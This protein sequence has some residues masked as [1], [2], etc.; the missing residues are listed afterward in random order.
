VARQAYVQDLR[1]SS[2]MTPQEKMR[3]QRRVEKMEYRMSRSLIERRDASQRPTFDPAA[4]AARNQDKAT[5]WVAAMDVR[6]ELPD[7]LEFLTMERANLQARTLMALEQYMTEQTGR[8]GTSGSSFWIFQETGTSDAEQ[9]LLTKGDLTGGLSIVPGEVVFFDTAAYQYMDPQKARDL[10]M[11]RIDYFV[12]RGAALMIGSSDGANPLI[13]E[14]QTLTRDEHGYQR[15]MNNNTVLVPDVFDQSSY[16][17]VAAAR[18]RLVNPSVVALARQRLTMLLLDRELE[19]NTMWVPI[20][21][22]GTRFDTIQAVFDLLPIDVNAKFASPNTIDEAQKVQGWIESLGVDGKAMLRE[23]AVRHLHDEKDPTKLKKG[24]T[25]AQVDEAITDFDKDWDRML[26]RLPDRALAGTTAPLVGED[27]FGTGDF[28]PLVNNDTG[29]LLLY[30]HGYKYPKDGDYR[31]Q[32]GNQL[33]GLSGARGIVMYSGARE[34]SATT[35]R[36]TVVA[37]NQSPGRGFRMELEIPVQQLGEKIVFEHNG[38]KYLLTDLPEATKVPALALFGDV[39]ID[40]YASLHDTISKEATD[41]L[42][43]SFQNAFTVFGIDFTEDVRKFFGTKNTADAIDLLKSVARFSDTLD[44]DEVYELQG[45]LAGQSAYMSAIEGMLPTLA[46]AGVAIDTWAGKIEDDTAEAAIARAMLLYAMSP[47]ADVE[48]ILSSSGFYVDNP[49]L[50]GAESQ[51]MPELF[52]R[53]FD[54]SKPDSAVRKELGKRINAKLSRGG[55]ESW[56]LDVNS[57]ELEGITAT[58]TPIRG[59]LQYG[60]AH[61]SEDSVV[62]NLMAQERKDSQS[63]TYHQGLMNI[64]GTGG[65]TRTKTKAFQRLTG[66]RNQDLEPIAQAPGSL[67]RDLTFIDTQTHGP[68]SRWQ[69]RTPAEHIVYNQSIMRMTQYRHAIDLTDSAFEKDRTKINEGID[70]IVNVLGLRPSQEELVHYWIRQVLYHPAEGSDQ[71]AFSGDLRPGDVLGATRTI[72]ENVRDGYFP[73]YDAAG[74]AFFSYDDLM[75]LFQAHQRGESTWAPFRKEGDPSSTAQKDNLGDWIAIAFGQAINEK[76][77]FDPIYRLDMAGFMNTY[78]A[79]LRD[80][81]HFMDITFDKHLQGRLLDPKT[82]ELL[83]VTLDPTQDGQITRSVLMATAGLEY[84]DLMRGAATSDDPNARAQAAAWRKRRLDSRAKWRARHKVRPVRVQSSRD[85][86]RNGIEVINKDADMHSLQRIIIALRHGTAMLNPGLYISMLPEQGWRMFLSEATNALSGESSLRSVSAVQRGVD[87]LASKASGGRINLQFAQYSADQLERFTR[88]I[89]E[90]GDDGAFTSLIISDM[91]WHKPGDSPGRVVRAFEKYASLGN[92]WQDPTWGTR[93]KDMARHYIEAIVREIESQPTRYAMS[94]DS[95]LD[96]LSTDPAYFARNHEELHQRA[97]NAVVDFRSLRN[98]PWSLALKRLYEPM[99]S[100]GNRLVR[101]GGTLLKLQAMYAT[102]NMNVLS[103]MTGMQ[104]LTAMTAIFFDAK[105]RPGSA[106]SLWWKARNDEEITDEDYKT[107]DMSSAIDSVNIA[108]AFIKGGVTQ[109]GLF[110]MGM[111]LG[112]VLSGEDDEAKR[113]RRLAQEQGAHLIMDPRRLETDFRN[114]DMI[115]LDWLPPQLG[116]AF[117]KMTPGENGEPGRQVAQMSWLIKPF[118]SPILGMEKFF[119]TGDF[120]YVTHGFMDAV[121]SLPL[122]NKGTWDDA[123]RTADE[124][125][126]L[127][128]EEQEVGTPTATKNTMWLLGSAVGVYENMLFENMFVNAIYAGLDT[129]DRDPSKMVLRDSDGVPQV[130]IEGNPRPNDVALQEFPDDNGT[131]DNKADDKI[132][133]GYMK[134]N[135][136]EAN[137]ASYTENHFTAAAVMSLFTGFD[138]DLMRTEMVVRQP[139]IDLPELDAKQARAAIILAT[140]NGQKKA[141]TLDRR[142]SLDEVTAALKAKY[143]AVKDWD[144]YNNLDANAKAFYL[145]SDNPVMD[146]LEE[147]GPDGREALNKSGQA[148]LFKGLMN[149]TITLEDE[150]MRGIAITPEVRKEIERDFYTDMRREGMDLGLTSDQAKDRAT[151]LMIGPIEDG[152]VM[153]FRDVLWSKEIPWTADLKYKQ[154]NTTYVTGPDGFPW[155]TGVKRGGAPGFGGFASRFG[156]LKRPTI[157]LSDA[158]TTDG[159]L[160]SVDQ[161][162]GVNTGLR[163]LVPLNSTELIPTDWEQTKMILDKLEDTGGGGGGSYVPNSNGGTGSGYG[164]YFY[165][166]GGGGGYGGSSKGYS[167][168]IY[169]SRQPTL[170]RGTN[171]FGNLARNLFWNNANI[172]RTTIRRERYQSERGRLA[173]WQ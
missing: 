3:F 92:K 29:E 58:G 65:V 99:S 135:P 106:L 75:V 144:G 141:G 153:G 149:G 109:T 2:Y 78:Q 37:I 16:Q 20:R 125:V 89:K 80:S 87:A 7:E 132:G 56:H 55:G 68:G 128:N 147:I 102:Y 36:G 54:L 114:K 85:F 103:T 91:M 119:M 148:A 62:Q 18:S 137:L 24:V 158:I 161:V 139:K 142:L 9:G 1:V 156:G 43:V 41:G 45:L 98:T 22:D 146:P 164:G 6:A 51:R 44:V 23:E 17:N 129:Y 117:F 108:N 120:G 159:R 112:G 74:P 171:V 172:R 155:A 130:D 82:N 34:P 96:N 10:A 110:M 173:Q 127:A 123:V 21:A 168:T 83:S 169:W 105:K 154:L 48:A 11:E 26:E 126:A 8:A 143:L 42:V 31:R 79:V 97:S 71:D 136:L 5:D 133:S 13:S 81:G 152:T 66:Q 118:L 33:A 46:D 25:Q 163:G 72:L 35:H 64:I 134:R 49:S 28:I 167:P 107:F 122:I 53:A 4:N 30:R 94:I 27:D 90:M 111:A 39:E 60:E 63:A 84:D 165:R 131:P 67:W 73:T 93:Q 47:G 19:E 140:I 166:G 162:H 160:N 170:P 88:L 116:G 14:L 86:I 76:V 104:G 145:S 124:L 40:G 95:V 50:V 113:R 12:S 138:R 61:A 15:Y 57:W 115:F 157:G 38:M 32:M 150:E 121:S 101:F 59:L 77:S 52:T 151:R 70:T 69:R 100:S